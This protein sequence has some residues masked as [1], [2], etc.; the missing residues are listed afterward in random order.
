MKKHNVIPFALVTLTF[1][2]GCTTTA[3]Q[4]VTDITSTMPTLNEQ[5]GDLISGQRVGSNAIYVADVKPG[6]LVKAPLVVNQKPGFVVIHKDENDKFGTI[7]GS[8]PL[9]PAGTNNNVEISLTES[10]VEGQKLYA[11]LHV[12]DGDGT[13]DPAKD[14]PAE[15]GLGNVLHMI[16]YASA[17]APDE[18]AAVI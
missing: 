2:A 11:M 10:T 18:P 4:P 1:L 17:D 14:L 3:P 15:D 6:N 16:F 12:D 8:S 7:I 13:F 9:V 5:P